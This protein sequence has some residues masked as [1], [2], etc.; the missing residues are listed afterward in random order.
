VGGDVENGVATDSCDGEG[1]EEHRPYAPPAHAKDASYAVLT[2][3]AG[4]MEISSGPG[5][6]LTNARCC[7]WIAASVH[8]AQRPPKEPRGVQEGPPS[9]IGGRQRMK[10]STSIPLGAY[11]RGR[12]ARLSLRS[13]KK[14]RTLGDCDLSGHYFLATRA[15]PDST[16]LLGLNWRHSSFRPRN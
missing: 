5:L 15:A 9:P 7:L 16:G 6:P 3:K 8:H 11:V 14:S 2:R 10:G 4:R 1:P 13:C 12:G